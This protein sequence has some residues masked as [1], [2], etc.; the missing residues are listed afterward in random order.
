[1]KHSKRTT[2]A[3]GLV[4]LYE[5]TAQRVRDGVRSAATLDMQQAHGRWLL[6]E[7]GAR[8]PLASIDETLLERLTAPRV[9]PRR[10]GASTMRKRLSTL[11][12]LFELAHRRRWVSRVPAWPAVI[13]PWRPR[14][15]FLATFEDARRIAD[16][17]PPHRALW[18]WICLLTGQHAGDVERMTW[19]DVDLNERSMILR[20]RKN[21]KVAGIRVPMPRHLAAVLRAQWKRARPRP[22]DRL[23]TPWPSRKHTLPLVCFRLGLPPV[24]AIDLRHTCATWMVRK[25]GITPSVCAWFGH[26]SPAMMARTYA[27]ALAPQLGECAA[28]LDSVC[29]LPAGG[30]AA[31]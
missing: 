2:L 6:A 9:P 25:V 27:H 3:Q 26:T 10:F 1:M 31:A 19:A 18:F 16:R 8:R 23:V 13:V 11:R 20:N 7:L 17:L 22:G 15:R 29:G 14:Q 12:Q 30:D 24:N 4:A 21:R 5:Q 28:E